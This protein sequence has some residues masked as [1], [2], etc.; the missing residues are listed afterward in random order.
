MYFVDLAYFGSCLWSAVWG[1]TPC[2][3]ACLHAACPA[4]TQAG[5]IVTSTC[6]GT[7]AGSSCTPAASCDSGAGYL[8]IVVASSATC[9][10]TGTWATSAVLKGCSAA[11]EHYPPAMATAT[12]YPPAIA[13]A[14][15]C[16]PAIATATHC[17]PA[18]ATAIQHCP[19]AMMASHWLRRPLSRLQPLAVQQSWREKE[20]CFLSV[21]EGGGPICA[22]FDRSL[23]ASAFFSGISLTSLPIKVT[24]VGVLGWVLSFWGGVILEMVKSCHSQL[25]APKF[26]RKSMEVS[27]RP[28]EFRAFCHASK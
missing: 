23:C 20:C 2:L 26:C 7:A 25:G 1:D 12:H 16:P 10:S 28:E 22:L 17:P 21:P 11:G 9:S 19:P 5:Y 24:G 4:Y 27:I 8:G 13:T 15:H 3:F 6:A 14:T 18:I